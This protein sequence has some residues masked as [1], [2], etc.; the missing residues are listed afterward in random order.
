MPYRAAPYVILFLVIAGFYHMA[1]FQPFMGEDWDMLDVFSNSSWDA[2]NTLRIFA[3]IE[4]IRYRPLRI[5]YFWLA[6]KIFG[7]NSMGYYLVFL[8]VHFFSACLVFKIGNKLIQNRWLSCTAAVIYAV[9][10][11]IHQDALFEANAS[12]YVMESFFYLLALWLF[13]NRRYEASALFWIPTLLFN[14]LGTTL[15]LVCVAYAYLF[16]SALQFKGHSAHRNRT[17]ALTKMF[18]PFLI[19]ALPYALIKSQSDSADL[20][21]VYSL[22]HMVLNIKFY[23]SWLLDPLTPL[24]NCVATDSGARLRW[25]G[26]GALIVLAAI[27]SIRRDGNTRGFKVILFLSCWMFFCVAPV[28]FLWDYFNSRFLILALPACILLFFGSLEI[29]LKTIL[30]KPIFL[31]LVILYTV[32]NTVF[33][34]VLLQEEINAGPNHVSPRYIEPASNFLPRQWSVVKTIRTDL[35]RNYPNMPTNA[36][37]IFKDVNGWAFGF[38]SGPSLWYNHRSFQVYTAKDLN[39]LKKDDRGYYIDADPKYLDEM[40]HLPPETKRV[41]LDPD[42]TFVFTIREGHLVE[43]T[44][45]F[46]KP[47]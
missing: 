32:Y 40:G 41:D 34:Y 6:Y 10:W 17:K 38:K 16:E 31:T 22:P 7:L 35:L 4:S 13:M 23:F 12:V 42:K 44:D 46:I 26:F 30:K 47:I 9:S 27:L 2:T 15:L 25:M 14:E 43:I 36:V 24:V 28:I 18:G 3:D 1:P 19:V 29:T 11:E 5:V 33:L 20:P 37:M 8:V 45:N 39:Y 21:L